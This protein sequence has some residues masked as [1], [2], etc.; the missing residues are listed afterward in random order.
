MA[1][2][3]RI[4]AATTGM[5]ILDA[6]AK[7][8]TADIP[9]MPEMPM[10]AGAAATEATTAAPPAHKKLIIAVRFLV[11]FSLLLQFASNLSQALP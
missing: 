5:A 7:A 6:V 8:T 10:V 2:H 4:T 3:K 1:T 9:A 11:T